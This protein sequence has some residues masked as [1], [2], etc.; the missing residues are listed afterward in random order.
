M[1]TA[2][3]AKEFDASAG[4]PIDPVTF[5]VMRHRL[6]AIN[7]EQAMMAARVSGS[8][9]VYEA[10]DFN[11]GI[12]TGDGRGLFVGVYIV[13]HAV[14]L[15]IMVRTVLEQWELND[16]REGDMFF[17]NDPWAGALH[18]NDGIM[19]SP[20]FW[21][22]EIVAWTG[23]VMH[24]SDVGS[25]VPGSFVVGAADRFGEAPLFPPVKMVENFAIR[26]DL[27]RAFLRNSRTEELNALNMRARV[28]AL[29]ITHQRIHELIEQYGIDTFLA[30]Q[31]EVIDYVD[32]IVRQRVRE[33]PDGSWFEQAYI[34]HDGNNNELYPMCARLTKAGDRITLDFTGTAPQA[35][36][37]INCTRAGLEGGAF[38]VFLLFLCYDIPWS[39]GALRQIIDIVSEEGTLNNARSPAAVSMGSVM[40]TWVTQNVVSN[41]AAKMLMSSSAYRGEAQACWQPSLNGQ[42]IAGAD[43]RGDPFASILMDCCGGGAGARTFADGI[44]TGGF[45]QSMSASI[46]N[47]ETT[48][49]RYPVLQVYRRQRCDSGGAGRYR[50][51]VAV[52]YGLLPHKSPGPIT[53]VVFTSGASQP[54][55][56][57][58]S[59]GGPASLALNMVLRSSNVREMYAAGEIPCSA[60]EIQAE[61]REV[62]AAK[63]QTMLALDDC[64][65]CLQ[66]GGGGYGDPLRRDPDAV[67]RDVRRGLVSADAAQSIYGVVVTGDAL[68][69]DATKRER[70]RAV[71]QRLAD[72]SPVLPAQLVDPAPVADTGKATHLH[73]VADTLEAVHLGGRDVVRCTVCATTL[74]PYGQD[75]K[76]GASMRELPISA[77]SPLNGH[78][79]LEDIVLRE[80]LCPTCGTS[81][82]LDVQRKAEPVLDEAW[83]GVAR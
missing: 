78:N 63:D 61:V 72:S 65:I 82:A 49:S 25:P 67:E 13:H 38:G 15:D 36:G 16:I 76:R 35:P 43:R 68:D 31:E 12:L 1:S 77:M 47:V 75:Y 8:P 45:M 39:V 73:P 50:G 37:S 71:A 51:G 55:G 42:V 27:E 19:V 14:P 81:I 4:G 18:A 21:S 11:S 29:T 17:S 32:R 60:D 62:L 74:S 46:P 80:Y 41:V 6:W 30:C 7:D 2:T 33:I 44:D 54:E 10:Y 66:T 59:G 53:D 23:I 28:A 34:D 24:D 69:V 58:L 40:G 26:P 79:T 22:G 83:F 56:H 9:V 5:E 20:I 48:E 57:G 70:E 64:H 3:K 52:E